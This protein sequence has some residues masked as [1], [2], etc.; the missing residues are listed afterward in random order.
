M[1]IA[2][3]SRFVIRRKNELGYLEKDTW[4]LHCRKDNAITARLAQRFHLPH[5]ACW[6][7]A[8][9]ESVY[10]L[11]TFYDTSRETSRMMM[12]IEHM[13]A[14]P[15]IVQCA[16]DDARPYS[17]SRIGEYLIRIELEII[18]SSW[19][20]VPAP[21]G[22]WCFDCARLFDAEESLMDLQAA[23]QRV[24]DKDLEAT[25]VAPAART[26]GNNN[27]TPMLALTE[28]GWSSSRISL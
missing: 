9:T 8:S 6:V 3:I 11:F 21:D 17:I 28:S 26:V 12:S 10:E 18:A 27:R 13:T 4:K 2:T 20:H 14:K 16:L 24:E 1:I 22:S 15:L 7:F 5:N 19:D 23:V 25:K